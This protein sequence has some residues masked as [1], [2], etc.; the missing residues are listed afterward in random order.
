VPR[1]REIARR[2][3]KFTGIDHRLALDLAEQRLTTWRRPVVE[4]ADLAQWALEARLAFALIDAFP[5]SVQVPDFPW[6]IAQAVPVGGSLDLYPAAGAESRLLAALLP[7]KQRGSRDPARGAYGIRGEPTSAGWWTLRDLQSGAYVR[8]AASPLCNPGAVA[9][10]EE[11]QTLITVP[12]VTVAERMTPRYLTA[13]ARRH[14][15]GWVAH[16]DVMGSRLLRRPGLLNML[17]RPRGATH[18]YTH[19]AQD[20]II[21]LCTEEPTLPTA[22]QWVRDS[23]LATSGDDVEVRAPQGLPAGHYSAHLEV[24][25]AHLC[26]RHNQIPWGGLAEADNG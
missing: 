8:V 14:K 1:L 2:T 20:I 24:G 19:G 21:E 9:A 11:G 13:V 5:K 16:R 10:R 7:R 18:V 25:H 12:R 3:K 23:G 17:A 4:A 6:A 26:L 15:P 22:Y